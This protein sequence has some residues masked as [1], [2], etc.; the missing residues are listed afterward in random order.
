[1]KNHRKILLAILIMVAGAPAQLFCQ[2]ASVAGDEFLWNLQW[3]AVNNKDS[4]QQIKRE[5]NSMASTINQQEGN[6]VP[7]DFSKK[8]KLQYCYKR[9]YLENFP[10]QCQDTGR[11]LQLMRKGTS[12]YQVLQ[13]K[14]AA[15]SGARLFHL[16][17]LSTAKFPINYYPLIEARDS[18]YNGE[19]T[20]ISPNQKHLLIRFVSSYPDGNQTSW[21]RETVYY[22]TKVDKSGE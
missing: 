22:F 18:K 1:M 3:K 20:A 11:P 21:Y 15:L 17:G 14:V 8:W 10:G 19:W 9:G 2:Q 16:F 13:Q 12:S 6:T 4:L 5:I 7:F